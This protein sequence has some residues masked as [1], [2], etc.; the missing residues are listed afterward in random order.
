M[1]FTIKRSLK[2]INLTNRDRHWQ[3][4]IAEST[5]NRLLTIER[6]NQ[7]RQASSDLKRLI[8]RVRQPIKGVF[9]EIQNTARNPERLL[10]KTVQGFAAHMSAKITPHNFQLLLSHQF[11]IDILAFRFLSI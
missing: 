5:G 8:S 10:N 6:C 2:F 11:E 1:R 3:E 7:D 4:E 9:H